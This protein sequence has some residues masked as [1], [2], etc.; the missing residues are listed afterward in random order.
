[1][2]GRRRRRRR[3]AVSMMKTCNKISHKFVTLVA[4]AFQPDRVTLRVLLKKILIAKPQVVA[5]KLFLQSINQSHPPSFV[6]HRITSSAQS[7]SQNRPILLTC[8]NTVAFS[9][10]NSLARSLTN[11]VF[12]LGLFLTLTRSRVLANAVVFLLLTRSLVLSLANTVVFLTPISCLASH[13]IFHTIHPS[14][15]TLR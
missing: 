15:P 11:T 3:R 7:T 8:A 10:T 9:L 4:C 5:L 6:S 12:F 1:M 14:K 13:R 2:R